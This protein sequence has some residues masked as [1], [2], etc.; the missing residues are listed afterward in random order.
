MFTHPAVDTSVPYSY[1]A[2]MSLHHLVCEVCGV[3]LAGHSGWDCPES[4]LRGVPSRTRPATFSTTYS[5][6]T[7]TKV[8]TP[9][10]ELTKAKVI[11]LAKKNGAIIPDIDAETSPNATVMF[12][13]IEE[14]ISFA[15]AYSSTK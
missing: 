3:T 13:S 10:V 8:S 11:E 9:M 15:K 1:P 7:T 6:F 12:R 4:I 14:L 5:T 2:M